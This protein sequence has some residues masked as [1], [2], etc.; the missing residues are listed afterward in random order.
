MAAGGTGGHIYPAVAT[1][2]ELRRRGYQPVLLGQRGG[3][4][5]RIARDTSLEFVGV[6]AGKLTRSRPSPRELWRAARGFREA[7]RFLARLRPACVV[8]YGGFASLPGVLGAQSLG[9]PSVL[10]EQNARLG[11]TQRL[12]LRR[13]AEVAT[14]Y[15]QVKGLPEGRGTLVGMPVREERMDRAEALAE[16]GLQD[17]PLTLYVTGGSQGSVAL[18]EA[19]PSVLAHLFGD[20]GLWGEGSVQVLHSTGLR[21]VREVSGRIQHL[22]WYKTSGFVNAVAAWSVADLAITRAGT[23]TLA[24]A[25]FHGVPLVMVPLPTSAENHQLYNARAVESAGAGRVVEQSALSHDLGRVVLSCLAPE[26]RR[27][28]HE[29]ALARSP[30]GAA[31]ALAD[32]VER[33]IARAAEVAR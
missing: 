4:E 16:L 13:A 12:A 25:A 27:A 30:Q 33:V 18:N 20:E 31:Q 21:W 3:M 1:A 8:G 29:R 26:S 2:Q 17:G 10:H 5:E 23:G 15:P 11:L 32:L 22:G 6:S 14:A 24:E 19:V 9:I 28:L 7:K